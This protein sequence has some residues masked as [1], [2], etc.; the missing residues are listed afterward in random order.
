MIGCDCSKG[1]NFSTLTEYNIDAFFSESF[2][3]GRICS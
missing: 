1:F 2:M 3:L